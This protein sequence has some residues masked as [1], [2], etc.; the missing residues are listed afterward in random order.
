MPDGIAYWKQERDKLQQQL[1]ELETEVVQKPS[2]SLIRYLKT[3]L[4]DLERHIASL[5]TKRKAQRSARQQWPADSIDAFRRSRTSKFPR[6]R[7]NDPTD[8]GHV[9]EASTGR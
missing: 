2:L 1:T 3:H 6:R 4:A 8:S 9:A 7:L 5:E